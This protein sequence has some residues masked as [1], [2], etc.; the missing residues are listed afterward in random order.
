MVLRQVAQ[1]DIKTVEALVLF[2]T[3]F[4]LSWALRGMGFGSTV[5]YS[6][7]IED[8]S[9]LDIYSIQPLTLIETGL[10]RSINVALYRG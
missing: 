1:V 8:P 10:G 7:K 9:V 4:P 2:V 6:L 5:P 3:M